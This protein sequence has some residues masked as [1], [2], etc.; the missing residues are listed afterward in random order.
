METFSH[1]IGLSLAIDYR[2]IF[3]AA[4]IDVWFILFLI[5]TSMKHNTS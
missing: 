2:C 1:C 4:D 5:V 3:K